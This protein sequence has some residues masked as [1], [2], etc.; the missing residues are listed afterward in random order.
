[1]SVGAR[2]IRARLA[3]GLILACSLAACS[4][5]GA[6]GPDSERDESV[7]VYPTSYKSDLLAFLRTYLN[8]PTNVRDAAIAEPVL[9]PVGRA[10]R[11]VVCIKYNA[12]NSDG[13][14]LGSKES[15]AVYLRG[16]FTQLV[17]ATG[18]LC[19]SA[20]Y[21]SFPELEALKR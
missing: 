20:T 1:M 18:D 15:V 6:G 21:Q 8:D 11:Y 3:T 17:E 7:N 2:S 9:T 13:R 5:F 12:R 14:Y 10:S 4:S 19:K 16:R